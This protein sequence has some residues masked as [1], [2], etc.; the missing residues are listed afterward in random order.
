[1]VAQSPSQAEE[2]MTNGSLGLTVG[3]FRWAA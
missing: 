1:M 2:S 3:A